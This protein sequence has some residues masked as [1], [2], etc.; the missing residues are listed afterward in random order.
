MISEFVDSLRCHC[1]RRFRR[2]GFHRELAAIHARRQRCKTAWQPHEQNCHQ[3]IADHAPGGDVALLTGAGLCF[4]LPAETLL[5]RYRELWLV[6]VAFHVTVRRLARRNPSIRLITADLTGLLA[7][8][9]PDNL[10]EIP[11]V[12]LWLAEPRIDLVVSS[13]LMTQLPLPFLDRLPRLTDQAVLKTALHQ[14]HL[15]WLRQFHCQTVLITETGLR[16]RTLPSTEWEQRP[17]PVPGLT[18]PPQRSWTWQI[19]PA[20]EISRTTE[21]ELTVGAWVMAT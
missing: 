5:T 21:V 20:G 6:D 2:F 4:D 15:D 12:D 10:A 16:H 1:P 3:V 9:L 14:A 8:G 18:T 13:N 7:T 19:A 11:S 17:S